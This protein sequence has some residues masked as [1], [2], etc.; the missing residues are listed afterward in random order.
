MANS[1][2]E[3]EPLKKWAVAVELYRLSS[4]AGVR[5]MDGHRKIQETFRVTSFEKEVCLQKD[6]A[7]IF[8][9]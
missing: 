1:L 5:K 2:P 4:R 9:N 7:A 3:L 6:Q 8:L